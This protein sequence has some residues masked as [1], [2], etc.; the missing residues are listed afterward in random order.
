MLQDA[1]EGKLTAEWRKQQPVVEGDPQLDAA[2]LLVQV[3]ADNGRLVN[4]G[5][6]REEKSLTPIPD[7]DKQF[8]TPEGW[9]WCS[10]GELCSKI[11]DGT[12]QTP[13]YVEHGR[14][15]LSA[16][17]IKPFKFMP[18][19]HKFVSEQAFQDC[20]KNR[21]PELGDVLVARVG[22]GIGEA[23]VIDQDIEFAF[24]VSLGL[25][26]PIHKALYNRFLAMLFNS[27][28]GV[29]YSKGNIASGGTSA[30]NFNLEKIRTFPVPLPPILEQL[31]I[32]ARV[33]NLM[34][35]IDELEKQV[36]ERKDHAQMLMQTVLREAFAGS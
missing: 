18:E 29:A 17:N 1:V 7:G 21:K 9:V 11:T 33:D 34:V 10:L 12:H 16:Q 22:A 4:E 25:V 15:F 13:T 31:A 3:M 32:V 19:I 26:K 14:M 6:I 27:P 5:K 35:V 23:A 30:G 28:M 36:A 8:D 24:Y 2:A 20:I